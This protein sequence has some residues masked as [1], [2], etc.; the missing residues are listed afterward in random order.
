[1]P[2]FEVLSGSIP[3]GH[4]ELEYGDAPMGVAYGRFFPL[5]AYA[6][7]QR[8]VIAAREGGSQADLSL[9]VRPSGGETLPAQGGVSIRDFSAELGPEGLEVE[10]LGI[11]YPLYEEL[12]PGHVAAYKARFPS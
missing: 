3:V 8:A 6:K 7:I 2:R 1:M 11:G 4:S 10:V 9:E 12:F 5:P